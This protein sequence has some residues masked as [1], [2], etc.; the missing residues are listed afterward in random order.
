ML[1]IL[2]SSDTLLKLLKTPTES[3]AEAKNY[4]IICA[5]GLVFIFGY[6]A[7][8]SIMR[9]LGDAKTPM[10][11]II[12][13]CLINII[14]DLWLVAY[15]KLGST[16]AAI[17]TV[18]SQALSMI[19]CIIYLKVKNFMFDFKPSSFSFNKDE[20]KIIIKEQ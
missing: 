2:L 8:S 14:L 17:A 13:A 9:G 1:F 16:G 3:F 7:L 4:L 6:N 15:L 20:F 19:L 10:V 5:L 12:L 18:F 11:F